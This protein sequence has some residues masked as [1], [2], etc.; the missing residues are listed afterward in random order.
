MEIRDLN[1]PSIWILAILR[2]SKSILRTPSK[3]SELEDRIQ[4]ID[5]KKGN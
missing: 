2:T 5:G 4:A 1:Y 3:Y